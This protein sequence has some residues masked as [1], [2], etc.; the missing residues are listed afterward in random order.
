[1]I[2]DGLVDI[3]TMI[4]SNKHFSS[5]SL[6]VI[7]VLMMKTLDY[8]SEGMQ[9]L[10]LSNYGGLTNTKLRQSIVQLFIGYSEYSSIVNKRTTMTPTTSGLRSEQAHEE[11]IK[12]VFVHTID[13]LLDSFVQDLTNNS[14]VETMPLE[15]KHM[16]HTAKHYT[17]HILLN[18]KYYSIAFELSNKYDYFAGLLF[19]MDE[20]SDNNKLYPQFEQILMEKGDV[21]GTDNVC[22]AIFTFEYLESKQRYAEIFSLG[23]LSSHNLQEFLNT[24]PQLAWMYHLSLRQY[25]QVTT[26]CLQSSEIMKNSFQKSNIYLSIGKLS[27]TLL[28]K[29][30]SPSDASSTLPEPSFLPQKS[31]KVTPELI[32]KQLEVINNDLFLLNAQEIVQQITGTTIMNEEDKVCL[33]SM[34]LMN[35]ILLF[36]TQQSKLTVELRVSSYD[37]IRLA[38]ITLALCE[39]TLKSM[40]TKDP[41]KLIDT[42]VTLLNILKQLYTILIVCDEELWLYL[43]QYQALSLS[44]LTQLRQESILYRLLAQGIEDM[45]SNGLRKDWLSID[46]NF[47]QS[48]LLDI[49]VMKKQMTETGDIIVTETNNPRVMMIIQECIQL[50]YQDQQF[51]C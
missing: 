27:A 46:M 17:L 50:V 30:Q 15:W 43:C 12:H 18:M 7:I 51:V 21:I 5:D 2:I 10:G 29:T 44:E 9:K 26:T 24:R 47:L 45:K 40:E 37:L 36:L 25:D 20:S 22:L 32:N 6:Y 31:L 8:V 4:L 28:S 38:G 49:D 39:Y 42:N 19:A 1:M 23:K 3:I 35:Q 13:L 16:Y 34:E 48:M 33:S 41:S 14:S 11:E